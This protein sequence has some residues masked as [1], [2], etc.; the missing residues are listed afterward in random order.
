MRSLIGFSGIFLALVAGGCS[1]D[2][3]FVAGQGSS[4]GTGTGTTSGAPVTGTPPGDDGGQTPVDPTSTNADTSGTADGTATGSDDATGGTATSDG[5]T[6]DSTGGST[7]NS[8]TTGEESTGGGEASFGPCPDG[9][10]DCDKGEVCRTGETDGMAWS[11]CTT[12]CD[13][14][15]DCSDPGDDVCV[16]I[17]GDG[18]FSNWCG[19]VAACS[20]GNP[21]PEGMTCLDGFNGG[22]DVCAWVE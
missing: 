10:G 16:D 4:T 3:D 12:A 20:F 7:G 2:E 22:T 21:C 9:K 1:D 19:P 11:L 15:R 6:G 13:D 5:T 8:T 14:V 17:P 18:E